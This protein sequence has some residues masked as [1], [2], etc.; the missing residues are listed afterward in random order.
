VKPSSDLDLTR[1]DIGV[2]LLFCF[3]AALCE[4]ID[5]QAAGVAAPGIRA[6]FAP[7]PS[8][9]GFFFIAG[10]LGLLVGAIGGGQLG[11]W[12]GRKRVLIASIAAFGLCSVASSFAWDLTSLTAARV[13]TGLGLGAA[14][15]NLIALAATA[16]PA[17]GRNA[18][19]AISYVGMPFGGA[20]ASLIVLLSTPDAWR[21]VFLVGG[22]APLLIVPPMARFM[23]APTRVSRKTSSAPNA[24]PAHRTGALLERGRRRNTLAL[25]AGFFFVVLTLHLMLNWLPLLMQGRG[26]DKSSAALA[27]IGFGV[28]GG[29]A[30][31]AIGTLLD[32]R[33][34]LYAIASCAMVL[35][36]ALLLLAY[37]P[38]DASAMCVLTLLVGGGILGMQVIL[39][40]IAGVSYPDR[41][42][43]SGIGA[44]IAIG[45]VGSL[46]GPAFAA[47]L[48]G[49]GRTAVEVLIGVLPIVLACAGCV[50]LLS[51]WNAG[52]AVDR[53]HP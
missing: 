14:M 52:A 27:Q 32:T 9:L 26:L 39:Y 6:E 38:A 42:R 23:R 31:L 16:S 29:A 11:D 41:M 18:S 50:A 34:R 37:A 8:A 43:G 51:G 49:A 33:W 40:G 44:A 45:R 17:R 15:P 2:T 10:N 48:L 47:V 28:G 30:A 24:A 5:V 7:T 12:L 4:G 3:A 21:H 53:R 35:P 20:I 25:W 1:R 13:A 46:A 22:I 36:V 19:I